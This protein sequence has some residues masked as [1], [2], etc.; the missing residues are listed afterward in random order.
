MNRFSSGAFSCVIAA[1]IDASQTVAG[2]TVVT[3]IVQ[4]RARG[5]DT[6]ADLGAAAVGA[7]RVYEE[8]R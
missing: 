3:E 8:S 4:G 1:Y 7:V 2:E 5:G 6:A